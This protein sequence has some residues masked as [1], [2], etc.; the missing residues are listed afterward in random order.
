M[1]MFKI[2]Q[3]SRHKSSETRTKHFEYDKDGTRKE[4]AVQGAEWEEVEFI[5]NVEDNPVIG[6]SNVEGDGYL[7]DSV[8][9]FINNPELFGTF[10]VGDLI[11]FQAPTKVDAK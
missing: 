6:I 3:V 2:T 5:V 8:K 4:R 10:K 9:M 1:I 11:P 7:R